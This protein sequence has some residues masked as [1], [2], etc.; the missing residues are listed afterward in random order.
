MTVT[1]NKKLA[2]SEEEFISIKDKL[3]SKNPQIITASGENLPQIKNE[4]IISKDLNQVDKLLR[5]NEEFLK[6]SGL[7]NLSSSDKPKRLS[8]DEYLF[9]LDDEEPEI[10]GNW[11]NKPVKK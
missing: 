6:N 2:N 8:E 5:E 11:N 7:L 3:V 10:L 1:K 9:K 4:N